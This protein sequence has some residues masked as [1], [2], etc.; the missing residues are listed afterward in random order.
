MDVDGVTGDQLGPWHLGDARVGLAVAHVVVG[1]E[2]RDGDEDAG[3]REQAGGTVHG[4]PWMIPG[5]IRLLAAGHAMC[6][7]TTVI[8]PRHA[9]DPPE[10]P[11][12]AKAI[13][14]AFPEGDR[15]SALYAELHGLAHG[16]MAR[17]RGDHTL[18]TTALVHEAW[19]RLGGATAWE[20]RG[21]FLAAAARSMRCILV[22]HARTR[23][24]LKRSGTEPTASFE[25]LA[26]ADIYGEAV[27]L[28]ALDAALDRL[29]TTSELAAR[30]VEL[31][32]FA[33][34]SH[35][36][37]AEACKLSKRTV[38]RTFRLARAVLFRDLGEA[39]PCPR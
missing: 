16:M 26:I 32:F 14:L 29:A 30:I 1:G 35:A 34:M 31:R 10:D 3:D 12:V 37:I 18:Q 23:G 24:R 6:N 13:T 17:E 33:G 38:E 7:A 9:I 20:D 15:W 5:R 21:Q 27:D 2:R 4:S 25:G 36:E 11:P 28:L 19:M 8:E 22:D 39:G